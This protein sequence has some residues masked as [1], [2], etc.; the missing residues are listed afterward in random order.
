MGNTI[1]VYKLYTILFVSIVDARIGGFRI[2]WDG[3]TISTSCV[4]CDAY[5]CQLKQTLNDLWNGLSKA[6]IG[7]SKCE[8]DIWSP[9]YTSLLNSID[10][11]STKGASNDTCGDENGC[12]G[13]V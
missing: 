8:G 9:L 3:S 4:S 1:G 7:V 13:L 11:W 2:D 12:K 6:E 10:I 5:A